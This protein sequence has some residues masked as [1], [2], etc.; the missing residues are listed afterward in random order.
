MIRRLA[1][2]ALALAIL[3]GPASALT[4][5]TTKCIQTKRGAYRQAIV[6]AKK[7]L[8]D[9]LPTCFGDGATC[10]VRCTTAQTACQLPLTNDDPKNGAL[11]SRFVCTEGCKTAQTTDIAKCKVDFKNDEA[12]LENCV[13]R[14]KGEGLSCRLGCTA[15]AAPALAACSAAFNECL[16]QCAS[17]PN[18]PTD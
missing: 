7:A 5:A 11:G 9:Q 8:A 3:A 2:A 15:A 1:V 4:K 10:A 16:Q 12:G 18:A 6:D 14:E 13:N 17:D